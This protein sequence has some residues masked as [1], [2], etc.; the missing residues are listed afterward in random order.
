MSTIADPLAQAVDNAE[1]P[2]GWNKRVRDLI[3]ER[4]SVSAQEFAWARTYERAQLRTWARFPRDGDVYEALADMAISYVTHWRAPFTGGD[5]GR[6]RGGTLVR[7]TVYPHE[8]EPVDVHAKPLDTERVE[9]EI[10]SEADRRSA[11]YAGFSLAISTTEL[12]TCF[13]LVTGESGTAL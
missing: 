10:V 2:A 5:T 7:V 9:R 11:K 12:N 3:A 1:L 13:R 4:R 8:P 6:L